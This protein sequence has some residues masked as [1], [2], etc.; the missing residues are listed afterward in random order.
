M[1]DVE[2]QC[3]AH[4]I[5]KHGSCPRFWPIPW[6]IGLTLLTGCAAPQAPAIQAPQW[7]QVSVLA[8][9]PMT[10]PVAQQS[11][12]VP[13][14]PIHPPMATPAVPSHPSEAVP[15]TVEGFCV[16]YQ[17]NSQSFSVWL[18]TDPGEQ[19]T[20]QWPAPSDPNMMPMAT[21]GVMLP[22]AYPSP[23]PYAFGGVFLGGVY[24]RPRPYVVPLARANA[25]PGWGGRGGRRG[26]R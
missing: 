7:V 15:I 5:M 1:G 16:S 8:A 10:D 20:L 25:A 23:Y 22:Y 4:E 2:A 18:P 26:R 11:C 19:L 14:Q 3:L 24:Y 9:L 21:A 17:F 6:A 12:P 13:S